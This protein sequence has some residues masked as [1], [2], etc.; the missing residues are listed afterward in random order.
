M[1]QFLCIGLYGTF[2]NLPFNCCA[3]YFDSKVTAFPKGY[4][5]SETIVA[6]P[7]KIDAWKMK[8]HLFQKPVISKVTTTPSISRGEK[9]QLPIYFRPFKGATLSP[10][11]NNNDR[12]PGSPPCSLNTLLDHPQK[13]AS[14]SQGRIQNSFTA[15]NFRFHFI[16]SA[17]RWATTIVTNGVIRS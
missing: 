10:H 13:N 2:I 7:L 1:A 12:Q 8:L 5:H 3:I 14:C 6:S 4:P 11:L 17:T 9:T 16:S 15:N